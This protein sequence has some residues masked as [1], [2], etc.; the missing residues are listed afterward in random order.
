MSNDFFMSDEEFNEEIESNGGG[1]SVLPVGYYEVEIENVEIRNA[2]SG[3]NNFFAKLT[4][5]VLSGKYEN[6]Y[7]WS[8]INYKNDNPRTQKIGKDTIKHIAEALGIK[9]NPTPSDFMNA[10][11]TVRVIVKSNDRGEEN[12]VF[13]DVKPE[14]RIQ[15][16]RPTAPAG[17]AQAPAASSSA[18]AWRSRASAAA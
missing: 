6:R 14:N 9:H 11:L 8:N 12:S 3:P 2:K 18:P 16:K 4:M 5:R 13:F 15:Q 10:R 1:F 17:A 7:L